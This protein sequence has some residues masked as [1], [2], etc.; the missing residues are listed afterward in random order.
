MAE[1][2]G[3]ITYEEVLGITKVNARE[4]PKAD[5]SIYWNNV[6]APNDEII[7]TAAIT[8]VARFLTTYIERDAINGKLWVNFV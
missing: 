3:G 1:G 4:W 2:A 7:T 8:Y 6:D 5:L